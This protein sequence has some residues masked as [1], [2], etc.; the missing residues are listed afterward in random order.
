MK[1]SFKY[2]ISKSEPL[3]VLG[4]MLLPFFALVCAGMG[5]W[6][7]IDGHKVAGLIMLL[8]VTQAFAFG[9][10]WAVKRRKVVLAEEI[11]AEQAEGQPTD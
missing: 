3:F 4:H 6:M 9:S 8:V 2:L 11:A 1:E 10:L 7:V 5:L